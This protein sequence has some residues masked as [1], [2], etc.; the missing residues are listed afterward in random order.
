MKVWGWRLPF[1]V[2]IPIVGTAVLLRTFMVESA[3]FL[4]AQE[5]RRA[6]AELKKTSGASDR[7]GSSSATPPPPSPCC[8]SEGFPVMCLLRRRGVA[9]ALDVL[10]VAWLASAIYVIY[11]WLPSRIRTTGIMPP[12]VSFGMVFTSLVVE[13]ASV[14]AGGWVAT[15]VPCLRFAAVAAPLISAS[16]V[17][18]IAIVD[19]RSIAGAWLVQ[20][21]GLGLCGLVLGIHAASFVYIYPTPIRSTGFSLAYNTGCA[22]GG[23]APA[24][25]SAL[26]LAVQQRG[27]ADVARFMPALWVLLLSVPAAAG[28]LGLFRIA[29]LVDSCG[30]GGTADEGDDGGQGGEAETS[31]L[32]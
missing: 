21:V 14:L 12:L 19:M 29:P 6:G 32:V 28:A 23:A 10:Y 5:Q 2:A 20:N 26:L 24:V 7:V 15:H 3:E 31:A 27:D 18:A 13:F 8:T 30:R 16:F 11:G 9:F 1:L 17:A 25:V 22:I 4:R